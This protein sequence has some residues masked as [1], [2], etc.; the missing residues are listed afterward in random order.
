M[1]VEWLLISSEGVV[2]LGCDQAS[3]PAYG[4]GGLSCGT[5]NCSQPTVY[6]HE[7]VQLDPSTVRGKYGRSGAFRLSRGA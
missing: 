7:D 3:A 4:A 1:A 2:E 6:P 5:F